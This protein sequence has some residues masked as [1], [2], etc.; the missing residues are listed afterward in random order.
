MFSEPASVLEGLSLTLEGEENVG[1]RRVV[2]L[3]GIPRQSPDDSPG[4][5]KAGF[6]DR[7]R[8]LVDLETGLPVSI[9]ALLEGKPLDR[10]TVDE[11]VVGAPI[12]E[13]FTYVPA[14]DA[15]V[16]DDKALQ[17]IAMSPS[18]ADARLTFRLWTPA[19][20]GGDVLV[21]PD[22]MTDTDFVWFP[23]GGAFPASV[24]ES[25]ATPL[26]GDG[27]RMVRDGT[28]ILVV[29]EGP[30]GGATVALIR[31]GTRI[32]VSGSAAPEKLADLGLSFEPVS[33]P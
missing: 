21:A 5:S 33:K 2:A 1:G 22:L 7:H 12:P 14:P 25:V 27:R 24:K 19:A 31:G 30:P 20:F 16:L 15:R 17:P 11:L 29:L 9:E 28:E 10:T 6:G 8:I 18:E 23:V 26:T 13:T 3:R 4:V 32:E